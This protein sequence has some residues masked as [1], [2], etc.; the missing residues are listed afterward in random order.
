MYKKINNSGGWAWK[1]SIDKVKIKKKEH[2]K[3]I[4][5]IWTNEE[6]KE[7]TYDAKKVEEK[8]NKFD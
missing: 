2:E 3:V 4:N 8:I 6:G 1:E 7:Y 5:Y